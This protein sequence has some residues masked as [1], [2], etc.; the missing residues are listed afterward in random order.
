[1]VQARNQKGVDKFF[2]GIVLGLLVFGLIMFLSASFGVLAKNEAK[3]YSILFNQIAFGLVGGLAAMW[4]ASRIPYEFWRKY[5]F[6]FF[7]GGL[8]LTALVFVPGLGRSHGGATR[9]LDIGTLSFQPVEFLKIT[10]IVYFAAWI[11]WLKPKGKEQVKKIIIPFLVLF[12][13]VAVVLVQQP[14][15]KSLILLMT[16][17]LVMLFV[18]QIRFKY[19]LLLGLIGLIGFAGLVLAK[20]YIWSRVKTFLDP[21]RDPSGASFQ[22]QQ[23]QIAIGAGGLWGRGLGQ[24]IQKFTYLPEPQGDSIFAVI[25]EELGFIGSMITIILYVLFALRGVR[26]AS[27]S[28]DMFSRLLVTGLVILLTAQSFLNIASIAG[29]FPL[30]G[31]PL[32]FVSHGGTSLMFSLFAVGIILNVSKRQLSLN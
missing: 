14:D 8:V 4:V 23:A 28:P 25:G 27:R 9:W 13:L 5:A 17:S 31:V 24:G 1:M 18:A 2:L 6:Y 26:I 7:L 10:F 15:T 29:V 11:A 32:V 16:S 30:T 3:F 19:I 12:L 22:L 20:P 21:S